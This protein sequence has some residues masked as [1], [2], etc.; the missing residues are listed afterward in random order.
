MR[1]NKKNVNLFIFFLVLVLVIYFNLIDD[2]FILF[3]LY[4]HYIYN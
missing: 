1:E 3:F 4:I 2:E